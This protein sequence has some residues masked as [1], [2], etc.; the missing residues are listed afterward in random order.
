MGLCVGHDMIFNKKSEGYVT[1][2]IDKDFTN[3][4]NP[5]QALLDIQNKMIAK[6][7]S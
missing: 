6:T 3:N 1:N 7:Q 4:N 2:L 5:T